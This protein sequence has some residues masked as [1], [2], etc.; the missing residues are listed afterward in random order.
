MSI[1]MPTLHAA[2]TKRLGF[3]DART[4]NVTRRSIQF[5]PA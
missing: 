1:G 5:R 4:V 3:D 2:S